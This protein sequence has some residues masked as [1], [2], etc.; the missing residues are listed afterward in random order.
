MVLRALDRLAVDIREAPSLEN[1]IAIVDEAKRYQRAFGKVREVANRA[2]K[3]LIDADVRLSA[4]LAALP[5][6]TGTRGQFLGGSNKAPPRTKPKDTAPSLAELGV[7][8]KWA[9]RSHKI[10]AIDPKLREHYVAELEAEDKDITP[11]T[12]L[13]KDRAARKEQ[14]KQT[15]IKATFSED[16]PFGTVVIDPPWD[17]EKIDRDV[18]PNQAEF[19]YKTMSEDQIVAFWKSDMVPRI[20]PDSHVFMWATNK[21]LPSAFRIIEAIGLRYV[22]TMVWHKSGGF[23]PID[24]PQYNCE[25]VLY[26]RRGSPIFIDTKDFHCCFG[27]DR[28]EHSR[29]PDNFYDTVRRVTGGSRIDVF[30]RECREGFAQYGNEPNRFEEV[31]AYA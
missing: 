29:K 26:A 18:R 1:L 9:A 28:R 2:G 16:G 11:R 25:F 22:L 19:A 24:L 10:G 14:V 30:S 12:L 8:R 27:G 20:E 17:V 4:E 15:I 23:Q 7:D 5:K 21:L 31:R 6:A 3:V 13:A